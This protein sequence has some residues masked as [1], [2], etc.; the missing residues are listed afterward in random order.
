V[1]KKL[2]GYFRKESTARMR[3][4][5]RN[6]LKNDFDVMIAKVKFEQGEQYN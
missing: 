3:K 4:R 2:I 1:I 6:E 5:L